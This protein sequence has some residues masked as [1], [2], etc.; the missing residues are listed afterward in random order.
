[1][2]TTSPAQAGTNTSSRKLDCQ[3]VILAGGLGTRMRPATETIPKPMIPVCG[4]PFLQHQLEL[5]RRNGTDRVLLLVSYLGEQIEQFFGNGENLKMKLSY[6]YEPS[7]LGTGGA[8]RNAQGNLEDDFVVL[9]GDTYL[10]ID[11]AALVADFRRWQPSATIVA[12]RGW[13][14]VVNNLVVAGDGRVTAYRK[15]HPEGMTHTD[16]GAIVLSRQVLTQ[17][18]E[19]KVC[20][21]E[22][23]IFPRLI[24]QGEMRAWTT[25]EPFF[26]MGSP[27]GLRALEQKLA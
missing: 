2:T 27:E 9:N 3:A 14:P 19:H 25:S 8:L 21:L 26:D 24:Q 12:G 13:V 6:A 7:P 5:L 10:D 1:M 11:Y 22:E 18:P 4:K 16:S 15:R 23:E 17:I 20:S